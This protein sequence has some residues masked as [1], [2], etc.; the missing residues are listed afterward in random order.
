MSLSSTL[1][2]LI[3]LSFYILAKCDLPPSWLGLEVTNDELMG[4]NAI[5]TLLA[6]NLRSHSLNGEYTDIDRL[7]FL[8]QQRGDVEKA[9]DSLIKHTKWRE[10]EHGTNS[11]M[12]NYREQFE[13][14]VLN[15]EFFWIGISKDNQCPTLV[16]RTQLHDGADYDEDP[17]LFVKYLI[18]MLEK[19]RSEWGIGPERGFCMIVDRTDAIRRSTGEVMTDKLDFTVIPNLLDLFRAIYSTLYD[20][21]PKLLVRAQVIPTSWFYST[22]WGLISNLMDGSIRNKFEVIQE[23]DIAATLARQFSKEIL[24]KRFGGTSNEFVRAPIMGYKEIYPRVATEVNYTALGSDKTC[25]QPE[26]LVSD[27]PITSRKGEDESII[28]FIMRIVEG[29]GYDSMGH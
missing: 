3:V 15:D 4:V 19:G 20:N 2:T 12:A 13:N 29:D 9:V 23:R 11:I 1:R 16:I 7:R 28:S 5:N 14:S 24:P 17:Q 18:F 6:Q 27:E 22:C 8:R 21:Y 26:A 10:S 25:N